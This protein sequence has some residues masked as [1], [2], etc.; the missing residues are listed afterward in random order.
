VTLLLTASG[1]TCRFGRLAALG[2]VDLRLRVGERR[3]VIG[4]NGSGKTTLLGVLAG[5]VRPDGGRMVLDGRDI[6]TAGPARR[7]RWGIARTF[8]TPALAD[9]LTTVEN[10]VVGGWRHTGEPW[11]RPGARWS[12][13]RSR[14]QRQLD[15]LGLADLAD[16]PAGWL[17]HGQRRLLEIGVALMAQPR[18][19][20]LDEPA[21]GLSDADLPMLLTC[22]AELPEPVAVLLVEH[23]MGVV[24]AFADIVTVLHEGRVLAERGS[25]DVHDDPAVAAVYPA[26][27]PGRCLHAAH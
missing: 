23:R 27:A 22:L 14:A 9:S 21:A 10:L 20:L 3:A 26:A 4:P 24:S 11:W 16:T 12:Q 17:A 19:L 2:G 18:L 25:Q 13:L 8:Q 5:T 15:R 6:T 7:A 1:V